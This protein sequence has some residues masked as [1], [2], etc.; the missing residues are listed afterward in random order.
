MNDSQK[1]GARLMKSEHKRRELAPLLAIF[2]IL[3]G[4]A[5]ASLL[6]PEREFSPNENRY[7][8][9]KPS[10]TWT[11]LM[12]GTFTQKAED[13]V[14]DQ[15]ALRDRWMEASSLVQRAALRLEIND[16]WL[17]RD[18]R[19]FAKVT[20]DTFDSAQYEKNLAQV[21]DFFDA[22][23][24]KD[25]RMMMVPTPAYMLRDDLPA[26]APLF[27]AE[28]CF[29][30]LLNTMGGQAIDLRTALLPDAAN[31]YYRTDHHW[32]TAGALLGYQCYR[33]AAGSAVPAAADYTVERH[34][35]FRGTLYSK[36]LDPDAAVDTVELYR[37][38]G[39]TALTVTYDNADHAGC[40]DLQKLAQKDMYEV[41]FGGNW[42]MVRITGGA[43]N[44]RRLL[45]LKD[46]YANALLPFAAADYE[47]IAAVDLRYYLG[48][49]TELIQTE[50]I[51]D[52][53]V[54]YSTS[55]FMSEAKIDRLGLGK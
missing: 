53:L 32:T 34:E 2:G 16:T 5:L 11:T 43:E 50:G 47:M 22:N 49:L 7:L 52:V 3:V 39:D 33:A 24:D 12:D 54:L 9:L 4:L 25:C 42:P 31:M 37:W 6:T 35:G 29:D 13:Y 41:F 27:D 44:G 10:L 15:I 30:T 36:V 18:G 48:S 21:K 46:S 17:G 8:Q 51:T 45:V 23:P 55:A 26:N 28:G 1:G 40:Y 19:Y 20:P 38:D 14:A